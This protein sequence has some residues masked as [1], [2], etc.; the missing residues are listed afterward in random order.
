MYDA[1]IMP[2]SRPAWFIRVG[3]LA[4][5][6][7]LLVC[8]E[9]PVLRVTTRL[10][11]VNVIVTG[12]DGR[13]VEGLTKDDFTITEDGKPQPIAGFSAER[14]R[15][16]PP[17]AD[18][19]PP[20]FYTNRYELKGG[21]PSGVTVILFDLMNTKFRDR[22]NARQELLKFLRGQ[23]RPDYRIALYALDTELLLLYDFTSDAARLIEAMERYRPR[24]LAGPDTVERAA[25]DTG[26]G[27]LDQYLMR[28]D[29]IMSDMDAASRVRRTA[30]ALEAIAG[31]VTALPGRKNLVWVT[32]GIPF[33]LGLGLR[34]MQD[35]ARRTKRAQIPSGMDRRKNPLDAGDDDMFIEYPGAQ[36]RIF[37]AENERVARA[38]DSADMAVYPVDAQGLVGNPAVDA[39]NRKSLEFEQRRKTT[40][41]SLPEEF[42]SNRETMQSIAGRT[43]GIAFLDENETGRAI[44]AAV[45]DSRV[46][47]VLTYHPSQSHWDGRFQRI[48]VRVNRPGVSVR[49]RGGYLAL[50]EEA[51][52]ESNRQTALLEDAHSPLESTAIRLVVA[53]RPDTPSAGRLDLR[54]IIEAKDVAFSRKDRSWAGKIDLAYVQQPTP[55]GKGTTLLKDNVELKL[56]PE[57]YARIIEEGLIIPKQLSMDSFAYRLKVVVRDA[58]SGAVGSVEIPRGIPGR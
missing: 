11:E 2:S 9:P 41:T 30:A 14:L 16:L 53:T 32:G 55:D 12:K 24:T 39:R 29:Q 25:P 34:P 5:A 49:H 47:Y 31:R 56:T 58:N 19:L 52:V 6:C 3:C 1:G 46:N 44:A 33:S 13:P 17:P 43:G 26:I 22:A 37:D 42:Y 8:Q 27:A 50:P 18:P 7:T 20:G 28:A 40:A 15:V 36:K 45:E 23:L 21:A 51:R 35:P 10:V 4:T 48:K 57:N 38:M 54:V